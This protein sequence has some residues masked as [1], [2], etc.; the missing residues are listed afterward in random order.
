MLTGSQEEVKCGGSYKAPTSRQ[1]EQIA[2]C[3][4]LTEF[5]NSFPV[6]TAW[7]RVAMGEYRR[8]FVD[9]D[10]LELLSE[11]SARPLR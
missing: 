3:T 11:F 7:I 2:G 1:K 9:D 4:Y 6:L 10:S 8:N 5:L